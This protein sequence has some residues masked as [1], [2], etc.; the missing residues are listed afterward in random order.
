MK[1]IFVL[2]LVAWSCLAGAGQPVNDAE[3]VLRHML[4]SAPKLRYTGTRTVT[5]RAGVDRKVH[6]E[7]I[8][9]DG[10]KTRV[11][12]PKGSPFAGQVIVE[13][14]R[15]RR[16][17]FPEKNEIRVQPPRRERAVMRLMGMRK[18]FSQGLQSGDGGNV[19]G[20]HVVAI[21]AKDP[22]GNLS[23]R[24]WIEPRSGM[25]LKREFY[26]RTGAV[27]GGF[28]FTNVN[29]NPR[30][31]SRDFRLDIRG[32][33]IVSPADDLQR[34]ANKLGLPVASLPAG[35]YQLDSVREQK[36]GETPVLVQLYSSD[37]Q[38]FSL[39]LLKGPV[40]QNRLNRP[41]RNLQSIAWQKAG[42]SYVLI[43][44]L[45]VEEMQAVAKQLGR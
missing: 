28:E 15:E 25:L 5:L 23:Q 4:E 36:F 44:D 33:K 16:H 41:G 40:D 7:L 14:E 30:I 31:D 10:R 34:I 45:P 26:D 3:H 12:F 38:R 21:T 13:T 18:R 20:L 27:Q 42:V 1:R 17:Y 39:F 19:A 22:Q 24:M 32:A 8:E 6:T 2:S 29:L 35:K 37:D 43:G 9:K 11:E